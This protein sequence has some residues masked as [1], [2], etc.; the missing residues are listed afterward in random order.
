MD[1]DDL[2]RVQWAVGAYFRAAAALGSASLAI[3]HVALLRG[4]V[5]REEGEEPDREF[6]LDRAAVYHEKARLMGR[7]ADELLSHSQRWFGDLEQ[8]SADEDELLDGFARQIEA[9]ADAYAEVIEAIEGASF[10]GLDSYPEVL[11]EIRDSVRFLST[12]AAVFGALAAGE[13][14][15]ESEGVAS[16]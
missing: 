13:L 5:N 1:E 8:P 2:T 15:E 7:S 3:R 4:D 6:L 10:A 16:G 11:E 12:E 14:D 9:A